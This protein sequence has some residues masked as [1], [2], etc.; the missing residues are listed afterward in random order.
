MYLR[1]STV[2]SPFPLLFFGG[3][4]TVNHADGIV[5]IDGWIQ[6]KAPARIAVLINQLRKAVDR[7]LESKIVNPHSQI[8]EMKVSLHVL[9]LP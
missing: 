1:D 7:S 9:S 3:E 6:M 4:L 8:G 5:T 2:V